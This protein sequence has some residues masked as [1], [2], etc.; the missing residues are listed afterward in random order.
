MSMLT[1]PTN[2]SNDT[3]SDPR[4]YGDIL[5][6]TTTIEEQDKL[7]Q[8]LQQQLKESNR[9]QLVTT[10]GQVQQGKNATRKMKKLLSTVMMNAILIGLVTSYIEQ[11]GHVTRDF[12]GSG[13]H[14]G[15]THKAWAR[16]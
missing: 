2:E 1:A 13:Q 7:I 16:S 9:A 10:G 5:V 11:F 4:I 6:P 3:D 8:Q 12:H 14:S 15:T